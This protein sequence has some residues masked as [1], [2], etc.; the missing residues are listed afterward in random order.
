MKYF[1]VAGNH[2][3]Y[4]DF[5]N[6]YDLDRREYVYVDHPSK[7]YGCNDVEVY[8]TVSYH[9]RKDL[10]DIMEMAQTRRRVTPYSINNPFL[11]AWPAV[12]PSIW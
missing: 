5:C 3:Q 7:F 8:Y 12:P 4:I 11:D 2:S 1:I 10:Q 9:D 6:R